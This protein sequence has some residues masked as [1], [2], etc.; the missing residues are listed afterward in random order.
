MLNLFSQDNRLIPLKASLKK[1]LVGFVCLLLVNAGTSCWQHVAAQ[2]HKQSYS[3]MSFRSCHQAVASTEARYGSVQQHT[4]KKN[5]PDQQGANVESSSAGTHHQCAL[6]CSLYTPPVDISQ[7]VDRIE[8]PLLASKSFY[9][10]V[11]PLQAWVRD[12]ERPPQFLN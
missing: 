12:L 5:K 10:I 2:S 7:H 9:L 6:S 8:N 3:S 4:F 1:M 11:T